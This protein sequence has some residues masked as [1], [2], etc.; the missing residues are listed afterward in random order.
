M[1]FVTL[2][3]GIHVNQIE[4]VKGLGC[5]SL[6]HFPIQQDKTER[7]PQ[8]RLFSMSVQGG[9]WQTNLC[10]WPRQTP[11]FPALCFHQHFVGDAWR[12]HEFTQS[13]HIKK[14]ILHT[15]PKENKIF[16]PC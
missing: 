15:I 12:K 9:I 16:L 10:L 14:V 3:A 13:K 8:Y 4:K 7:Y 5:S 11:D 6:K 2:S 1:M